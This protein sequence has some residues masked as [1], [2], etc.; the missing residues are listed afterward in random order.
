MRP[1]PQA[2]VRTLRDAGAAGPFYEAA[3]RTL[4]ELTGVLGLTLGGT[5]VE[6]QSSNIAAKPFIELL[7]KVRGDLR[8]AKQ[9]ALADQVRD[10][11]KELGVAMEDSPEGTIWRYQEP[12]A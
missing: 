6:T 2:G 4:R 11:L 7:V 5:P 3:Q 9:W 8:A 1:R 12:S 10:S